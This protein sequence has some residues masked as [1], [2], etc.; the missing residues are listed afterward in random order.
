MLLLLVPGIQPVAGAEDSGQVFSK[1]TR[2][3]VILRV[4]GEHARGFSPITPSL[5]Y[6]G[7]SSLVLQTCPQVGLLLSLGDVRRTTPTWCGRRMIRGP[8]GR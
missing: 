1:Q 5:E 7:G 6:E 8:P 4:A 3:E 2:G